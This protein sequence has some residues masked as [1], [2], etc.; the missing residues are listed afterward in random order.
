MENYLI[1]FLL[2]GKPEAPEGWITCS[3]PYWGVF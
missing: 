1:C 3:E 2:D